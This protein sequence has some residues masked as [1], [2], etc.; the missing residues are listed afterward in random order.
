MLSN[1]CL[2]SF[3]SPTSIHIH[4]FFC[5]CVLPDEVEGGYEGAE[6]DL[7]KNNAFSSFSI[8]LMNFNHE[9][10][11]DS[12]FALAHEALTLKGFSVVEIN[13]EDELLDYVHHF[14]EIW[15]ASSDQPPKNAEK[16]VQEL[17]KFHAAGKG[18]G[19]WAGGDPYFQHANMLLKDL[20]NAEVA[21]SYAGAGSLKLAGLGDQAIQAGTMARSLIT[22][23]LTELP[24]SGIYCRL[25]ANPVGAHAHVIAR[26]NLGHPTIVTWEGSSNSGRVLLSTSLLFALKDDDELVSGKRLL[27]NV[28]VW[29]LGLEDRMKLGL[30]LVGDIQA[31]PSVQWEYFL[32]RN[33][34]GKQAGWHP[35][36][37]Q[38][39]RIVEAAYQKYVGSDQADNNIRA[40]ITVH[41]GS[42]AYEV[43]FKKMVQRNLAHHNHTVRKVRRV[44]D[45]L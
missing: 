29:L 14:D 2:F 37:D 1:V 13:T 21:D 10:P 43:D 38:G 30:S 41:S 32:E 25:T 36:E 9:A 45:M 28:G 20:V 24:E 17:H 42:F 6:M 39:N 34:D 26:S 16:I 3:L 12:I 27:S 7:G 4:S 11:L 18:I 35:Y 8:L 15:I 40:F 19:I 23:G 44:G 5:L 31:K 33:L 22:T